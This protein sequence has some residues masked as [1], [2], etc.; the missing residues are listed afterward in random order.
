MFFK[1][2]KNI[3]VVFLI[4]AIFI[5]GC[6]KIIPRQDVEL[7]SNIVE[8][9]SGPIRSDIA[10]NAIYGSGLIRYNVGLLND[11]RVAVYT[12]INNQEGDINPGPADIG[13]NKSGGK[14]FSFIDTAGHG[15]QFLIDTEIEN[16]GDG[17]CV[18]KRDSLNLREDS[19]CELVNG[20]NLGAGEGMGL[21]IGNIGLDLDLK[22]PENRFIKA[23]YKKDVNRL[24]DHRSDDYRI[25]C[26]SENVIIK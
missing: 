2:K 12:R 22:C 10:D 1:K 17:N 6:A 9:C 3:L 4:V 26:C 23:F 24:I 7:P 11:N 5:N 14:T 16:K 21:G 18:I 15:M 8:G 20:T 25:L 13:I 19:E